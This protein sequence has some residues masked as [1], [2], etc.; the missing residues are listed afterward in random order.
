[1]NPEQKQ[2]I[3]A[4]FIEEAREH[5]QAID[6]GLT[7]L[8]LGTIE[9]EVINE[10]FRAA[11]SIK[12]GAAMLGFRI[13]QQIAYRFEDYFKVLQEHSGLQVNAQLSDSF[14]RLYKTLE[15][16]VDHI[17]KFSLVQDHFSLAL[18]A[19]VE[20][21][22]GQTEQL[23][24]DWTQEKGAAKL[25]ISAS[26][27]LSFSDQVR[28]KLEDMEQ[29]FKREDV[30]ATR[31]R[32]Q[33]ICD[34]LL[35]LSDRPEMSGWSDLI[36]AA[37]VA[38]TNLG[39]SYRTLAPL[40]VK[41]I[42]S[43]QA[44]VEAEQFAEVRI[45]IEMRSLLPTNYKF[46]LPPQPVAP[47]LGSITDVSSLEFSENLE[48]PTI[49]ALDIC[50]DSS[51][52]SAADL[53]SFF[54]EGD[55][56]GL[57]GAAVDSESSQAAFWDDLNLA[58][59]GLESE[60]ESNI[61]GETSDQFNDD[62]LE[63]VNSDESSKEEAIADFFAI[64]EFDDEIELQISEN[65][66]SNDSPSGVNSDQNILDFF[67]TDLA[68][69]QEQVDDLA[70]FIFHELD[71]ENQIENSE[72]AIAQGTEL[73]AEHFAE[74][75]EIEESKENIID[76]FAA[77]E[78]PD[79]AIETWTTPSQIFQEDASED[80]ANDTENSN[81]LDFFGV[82]VQN[83]SITLANSGSK[84][85][86]DDA[87]IQAEQFNFEEAPQFDQSQV[88]EGQVEES[89]LIDFFVTDNEE[90]IGEQGASTDRLTNFLADEEITDEAIAQVEQV[91]QI[92]E[93]ENLIDFF[94]TDEFELD[95][96][97]SG[98]KESYEEVVAQTKELGEEI[99]TD[100]FAADEEIA[101]YEIPGIEIGE[102]SET[103]DEDISDFFVTEPEE[104]FDL[105]IIESQQILEE[106]IVDFFA[107]D[108]QADVEIDDL[109]GF[110][111]GVGENLLD[112]V[113]LV[114]QAIAETESED[115]ID[116][117]DMTAE[118]GDENL[119][120]MG[121]FSNNL[122]E[123]DSETFTFESGQ[124]NYGSEDEVGDFF[125]SD[126]DDSQDL[127]LDVAEPNILINLD[128]GEQAL[129]EAEYEDLGLA[130]FFV[131]DQDIQTIDPYDF[132]A[133]EEE[134]EEY[135]ID[136]LDQAEQSIE[137]DL[138]VSNF[139]ASE[140]EVYM[141]GEE[142]DEDNLVNFEI[143][144]MDVSKISEDQQNL[145]LSNTFDENEDDS[146]E[147]GSELE[148]NLILADFF[149]DIANQ[150]SSQ[151][152]E[153][154]ESTV[155]V[156]LTEME[157]V[158]GDE[159]LPLAEMFVNNIEPAELAAQAEVQE[160]TQELQQDEDFIL[161]EFFGD[162][163]QEC[164]LDPANE[165]LETFELEDESED[166][167]PPSQIEVFTD[168]DLDVEVNE[169]DLE[170]ADFFGNYNSSEIGQQEQETN[171]M[172]DQSE[173]GISLSEFFGDES[174][175]DGSGQ[176]LPQ[177]SQNIVELLEIED[178][179]FF[180]ALDYTEIPIET[181]GATEVVQLNELELDTVEPEKLEVEQFEAEE[182]KTEELV[183]EDDFMISEFF[184][185]DNDSQNDL[186]LSMVI[187]EQN[188]EYDAVS[189]DAAVADNL[190]IADFFS[191][192]ED[193]T[194]DLPNLFIDNEVEEAAIGQISDQFNQ[195]EQIDSLF[196]FAPDFE[197]TNST[198]QSST[199]ENLADF[200][201][202]E[203]EMEPTFTTETTSLFS[204]FDDLD[205]MLSE[206]QA[207]Q[208]QD[209]LFDQLDSFLDGT[210]LSLA[211]IGFLP[212]GSTDSSI[213][214]SDDFADLE[215]LLGGVSE[216]NVVDIKPRRVAERSRGKDRVISS[217]MKVDVK[218]LDSLN[219]LVGELVVNRNLLESD[220]EK[221]QQF[222]A[223]LLFQVQLLSDVSQRMR[224]HYDRSL[225]ENSIAISRPRSFSNMAGMSNFSNFG[226]AQES[227]AEIET[228]FEPDE[229]DRYSN[230]HVL[231]QEIIELIVKV[232]E[233]SSDIEFVVSE[234]EQVSRQL[235]TITK[236]IQ[237]DLKQVRMLPFTQISERLP[238]GVRDRSL[239]AGK[240][241]DIVVHGG[242]T[243]IDKAILEQLQDP[244]V[245]LINNAID[246][247]IE[248]PL[249]RNQAG[250]DD[251]GVITVRAYHQGNQTVI[252]VSDD[253]AGID[254]EKVKQSAVR[255][256]L[257][258][259]SEVKGLSNDEVYD[260][261]FEPGF[262]TA[263][264][265]DIFKGRG[266][267]MDVVKSGLEDIRGSVHTE[268][269]VGKG[270][271]F[272]IRLPLTLSVSKAMFCI[273]DRNRIAFPVDG[274]EDVVEISGADVEFNSK[275]QPCLP[276]RD[277]ILPFRPLSELLSFNRQ[278]TRSS[279]YNKQE[280]DVLS[281]IILRNEGNYLALQV[282]QFLGENE[283][284]IK[285]LEG[286]VPKPPGIAGA[287][288]LGDGKVMAI[289]NVLELFDIASGRLRVNQQKL[290]SGFLREDEAKHEPL[291][292]IVDDSVT[293]RELLSLTFSKIGYRVEQ[294]KDGQDAWEKLRS[295]LPCDLIFCDVEMPRMDGFEL[296][297]RIQKD[298]TLNKIP[299]SMLTSRS[300]DRHRQTAAQLGASGYFTKP[301]LEEEILSASQ[302]LIKGEKLIG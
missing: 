66:L 254:P 275:G 242:D 274:F 131:D 198:T 74:N 188:S 70:S 182:F 237:E 166:L 73:L 212:T 43:S 217:T 273:S 227:T 50:P 178:L 231:S 184:D 139:F 284:V 154:Q 203:R 77:D 63:L 62:Q 123:Q 85:L 176:D 49:E 81:S 222:I 247:G 25:Q 30:H 105:E 21:L 104:S 54:A 232:R 58:E 117:F 15:E 299:I 191:S 52:T 267:G 239:Q 238:R 115:T 295:G 13:V 218:N 276:W 120:L 209:S 72:L 201:L 168:L 109:T 228:S 118:E 4:H 26:H 16:A 244:M 302:R 301:Y 143:E 193:S 32:L 61:W 64:D 260:L 36:G 214:S 31:L 121:F 293:V 59:S 257:R 7:N 14:H 179:E 128:N 95:Q 160:S 55:D 1:M 197:V 149:S 248:D 23:F 162:S 102:N 194:E 175:S 205:S 140:E 144:P 220:N 100:F 278:M 187:E 249:T 288:I 84:K 279:M 159:I 216:L 283:I 181:S 89:T 153:F 282:D 122:E 148:E 110:F 264:Q 60:P 277:T 163:A 108:D 211:A 151:S 6:S 42:K 156:E 24:S 111:D 245:H 86:S 165:L 47:T 269:A 157:L 146:D 92:E 190:G 234:A 83:D 20:P 113:D 297:S 29:I 164:A 127:I 161:S 107:G 46:S 271:T 101:E 129:T 289:A 189:E 51:E 2:R 65:I 99:L 229:L 45:P 241:A 19:K 119:E 35:V 68:D 48:L 82:E 207:S 225:L 173:E 262:S 27:D 177:F 294:A 180:D 134:P 263:A 215:A 103:F 280:D 298:N 174:D 10:L 137:D 91:E 208:T 90:I 251:T 250:K 291:V 300:N 240:K 138:A 67:T 270:T 290:A 252:A 141:L 132:R 167:E 236:Q 281:V 169:D 266:V 112:R 75:E 12:G 18:S 226:N 155:E 150:F 256:G 172:A 200:F 259:Q 287:T 221:L 87:Y 57:V 199:V 98:E 152:Q 93:V 3:I 114:D 292:L 196:D 206:S 78:Q 219:N 9:T 142:A 8:S 223:N 204:E 224:D 37:K 126:L 40:V 94:I 41:A 268:S 79:A 125:T 135:V 253:G 147:S 210:P 88:I 195:S 171:A 213:G 44:L 255:K 145:L 235:G 133:G 69:E 34:D 233:S 136:Y 286:P 5:L 116:F 183:Y 296:L 56:L 265:A 258:T 130:D 106:N 202:A 124:Q 158:K 185:E 230:F 28:S 38:I 243:L 53:E 186:D 33:G 71:T 261:L 97:M 76:F 96:F 246:H 22:F 272:T 39:N 80:Q 192:M 17:E 11:H 170:L 285:N